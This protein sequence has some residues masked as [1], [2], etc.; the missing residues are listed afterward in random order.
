MTPRYPGAW[1]MPTGPSREGYNSHR[2]WTTHEAVTTGGVRAIHGWSSSAKACHGFTAQ[3]GDCGQFVDFDQIVAG[4]YE[5]NGY[6]VTWENWDDLL[7]STN[8]SPDGSHGPNDFPFSA[9]QVERNADIAAWAVDAIGIPLDWMTNTRQAGH[10]PH[11]LGVPN[12]DGRINVGYGPDQWTTHPGKQCPGDMR[13]IQLRDVIL[14]RA[15]VILAAVRAGRC[16]WLPPGPVNLVAALARTGG[17][18]TPPAPQ[19]PSEED[20]LMGVKDDIL[21]ELKAE[22][23]A[24]E[25]RVMARIDERT[26]HGSGS[27][28][29]GKFGQNDVLKAIARG[30]KV[31]P[32]SDEPKAPAATVKTYTVKAGDTLSKIAAATGKSV[33]DLVAWNGL[34]NADAIE[35]GQVLRLGK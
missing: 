25:R 24:S 35:A 17:A 14:P 9:Q 1:W 12:P 13:I 28:I 33:A 2:C 32:P 27:L 31:M 26:E 15:R 30:Q 7:P 29:Y 10:A 22:I 19:P 8:R 23:A 34:K 16:T 11:R 21:K 3:D 4:T 5:G 20:E 6:A 18:V